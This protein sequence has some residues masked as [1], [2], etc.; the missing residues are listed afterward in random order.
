MTVLRVGERVGNYKIEGL[1][2]RGGQGIVYDAVHLILGTR[3]AI[4]LLVEESAST[5]SRLLDEGRIQARLRHPHLVPVTDVVE[6]DGALGL[7]AERVR[8]MA[9]DAWTMTQEPDIPTR[10]V[11]FRQ[12]CEGL[13]VA[14]A[15]GV[16]HRDLKPENILV[17]LRLDGPFARVTDFGIAKSPPGEAAPRPPTLA[18]A[19]L[20]TFGYMAPEQMDDAGRVDARADVY[21]L[22]C[23]LYELLSGERPFVDVVVRG[24]PARRR[25]PVPLMDRANGGWPAVCAAVDACLEADPARRPADAA[26]L[27]V[28]LAASSSAPRPRPV[29]PWM[30]AV[31]G[32]GMVTAAWILWPSPSIPTSGAVGAVSAA[33]ADPPADPPAVPSSPAGSQ[34]PEVPAPVVSGS[35][36]TSAREAPPKQV[37][38]EPRPPPDA[39]APIQPVPIPP[40]PVPPMPIPPTEA[41]SFGR[42]VASGDG[43]LE[44]LTRDGVRAAPARVPPGVWHMEV[45]FDAAAAVDAGTV[46]VRGGETIRVQCVA[47]F[48]QCRVVAVE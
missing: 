11:V 4:K 33:P 8:G 16:V 48:L 37:P 10:M 30:A 24:A 43:R 9:L 18:G 46:S 3:H 38:T 36:V 1:L 5:R 29:R 40:M 35:V 42:V 7:V 41:V 19:P 32:V 17:E 2:G 14:H 12:V 25:R 27:L 39:P 13:A 31:G 47:E 28:R 26:A 22:G 23:I 44:S 6:V 21:A 45:Q 34:S 20:G 15:A